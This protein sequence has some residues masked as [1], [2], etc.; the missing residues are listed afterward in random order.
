[1]LA[2]LRATAD[3]LGDDE[4]ANPLEIKK[5]SEV[6]PRTPKPQIVFACTV[7]GTSF[8]SKHLARYCGGA[9]RIKHWRAEQ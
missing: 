1:M 5:F 8:E 2:A 4:T 6:V 3:P 9:C 7:C